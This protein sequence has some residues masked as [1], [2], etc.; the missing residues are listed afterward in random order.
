MVSN[1]I[2]Q[3]GVEITTLLVP[4]QALLLDLGQKSYTVFHVPHAVGSPYVSVQEDFVVPFG[5]QSLLGFGGI[6]PSGTSS[7]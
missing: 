2:N 5:I 7:R 6:L 3:L 1:L 4:E